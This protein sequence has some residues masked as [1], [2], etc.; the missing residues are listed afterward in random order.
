MRS[1]NAILCLA[2]AGCAAGWLPGPARA[3]S[4]SG[5][6]TTVYRWVDDKGVVHYG[7]SVPPEFSQAD[8]SVLNQQGVEVGHVEGGKSAAQRGE[9]QSAEQTQQRAQH[10]RF[11]LATYLSVKDIEQ[12]RDERLGLMDAQIKAAQVYIDNLGTRLSTLQERALH[13]KPYSSEHNARRMPDD[14]AEQLVH[15]LND[16]HT[17]QQALVAKRNEQ[18]EAR[19]QFDSDI[20]RYRELTARPGS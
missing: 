4:G 18:S 15:T 2:M 6:A 11:L 10:D 12:L 17:Q 1:R 5:S 16:V 19:S 14:L 9:Q 20:R 3:A 13:F 8:R 7:D